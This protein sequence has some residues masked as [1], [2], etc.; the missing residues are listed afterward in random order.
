MLLDRF[1]SD[2]MAPYGLV[3]KRPTPLVKNYTAVLANKTRLV[4]WVVSHCETHGEREAY[5]RL[6]ERHLPVH[7]YGECGRFRCARSEDDV[8]LQRVTSTYKFFLAFENAL[9]KDYITEKMFRYYNAD[10]VVVVRGSDDYQVSLSG[11]RHAW[12]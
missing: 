11:S 2:I 1:D 12:S 3:V 5:V 4:S 10:V 9:C 7:K 6:L 8:C